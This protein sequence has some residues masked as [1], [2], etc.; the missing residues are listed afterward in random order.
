MTASVKLYLLSFRWSKKANNLGT[1]PR[2]TFGCL[3]L[4]PRA[5]L[6]LGKI[7]SQ[8]K[9]SGSSHTTETL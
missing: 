5:R 2:Q 8:A 6:L 3:E 4:P 7:T 1:I 9:A